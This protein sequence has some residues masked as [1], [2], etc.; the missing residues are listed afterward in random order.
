MPIGEIRADVDAVRA[1][2][3]RLAS[4]YLA[5][6]Q[7]VR[8]SGTALSGEGKDSNR[9][10]L[11]NAVS[12]AHLAAQEADHTAAAATEAGRLCSTY[13]WQL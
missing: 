5:E 10:E 2:L 12:I 7:L 8:D 1:I 9:T 11:S 6:S 4:S 3:D 13:A